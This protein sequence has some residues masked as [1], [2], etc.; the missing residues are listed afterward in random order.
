MSVNGSKRRK[1]KGLRVNIHNPSAL[2]AWAKYWDCSQQD[3]RDAVK[4]SGVMV[5]DVHDWVKRN[6][7]R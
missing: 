5:E 7:V 2:R 6:V 4:T 1:P 3:I